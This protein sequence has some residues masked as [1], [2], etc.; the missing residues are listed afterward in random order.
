MQLTLSI[1]TFTQHGYQAKPST[2]SVAVDSMNCEDRAIVPTDGVSGKTQ[3]R[4][5][6]SYT[7]APQESKDSWGFYQATDIAQTVSQMLPVWDMRER[8]PHRTHLKCSGKRAALVMKLLVW[9]EKPELIDKHISHLTLKMVQSMCFSIHSR[10]SLLWMINWNIFPV[11]V[12][13]I[14]QEFATGT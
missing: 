1:N 5:Q 6:Q 12:I 7:K 10:E 3:Q 11:P 2:W 14:K 9:R 4:K 8:G 13:N